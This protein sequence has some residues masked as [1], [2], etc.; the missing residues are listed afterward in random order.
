MANI[1]EMSRS[2]IAVDHPTRRM[3]T[4]KVKKGD[5]FNCRKSNCLVQMEIPRRIVRIQ[6]GRDDPS[7]EKSTR[8]MEVSGRDAKIKTSMNSES[9]F[10]C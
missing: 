1:H 6:L 4:R 3:S 9:K 8:Q 7:F 5:K 10:L 2:S